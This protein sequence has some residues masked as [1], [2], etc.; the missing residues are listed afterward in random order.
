MRRRIYIDPEGD[1]GDVTTCA[2]ALDPDHDPP[3][4]RGLEICDIGALYDDEL[5]RQ[6]Q[7]A[8][9]VA[10][11]LRGAVCR[12][13]VYEPI[14]NVERYAYES[15]QRTRLADCDEDTKRS[16]RE[17]LLARAMARRSP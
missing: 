10:H 9:A 14:D 5:W 16:L 17:S 1:L 3:G 4:P 13:L 8:C 15:S 12:A 2:Y 7:E 6:Y 11:R